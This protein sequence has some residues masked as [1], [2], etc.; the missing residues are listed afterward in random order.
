[1]AEPKAQ[2]SAPGLSVNHT[3]ASAVTG[4]TLTQIGKLVGVPNQDVA[5]NV[6]AGFRIDGIF[7]IV[8]TSDTGAVGDDVYW[9]ADGDPVVGTAG[10]GACTTIVADG[11]YWI[12]TL[13]EAHAATDARSFVHLNERR[14]ASGLIAA[15]TAH[16]TSVENTTTETTFDNAS[17]T[18]DGTKVKV[19]DVYRVKG[20]VW[21][22]DNNST[23]TLTLKLY[24]GTEVVWNSGAVDVA[25]NDMGN[26]EIDIMV[27]T[28]GS[29]GKIIASGVGSLG[30]PGTIVPKTVYLAEATEDI[31]GD[32]P[33]KLTGTWSVAHADNE[34]ECTRFI[35]EKLVNYS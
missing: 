22:E 17:V 19:G 16:S 10:S 34:C 20:T 11:D 18:I 14:P 32:F 25:D 15:N 26:I 13:A 1:M 24:V 30:V 6:L 21:V 12:G 29:S 27:N 5:A 8:A 2:F 28:I 33:I 23:D 35:V 7:A 31:S 3:P 4:G 9:D